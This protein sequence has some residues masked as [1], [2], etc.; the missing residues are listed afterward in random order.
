MLV[1]GETNDGAKAAED[2]TKAAR[3]RA[4]NFMID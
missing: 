4:V 3:E 2:E 1:P